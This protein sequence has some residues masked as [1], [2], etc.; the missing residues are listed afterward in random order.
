MDVQAPRSDSELRLIAAD[1]AFLPFT[2]LTCLV[3][4][5]GEIKGT[6]LP[7][8]PLPPCITSNYPVYRSPFISSIAS[9]AA[10]CVPL[11]PAYVLLAQTKESI[12]APSSASSRYSYHS[13]LLDQW[14]FGKQTNRF[15]TE[16]VYRS[17][18]SIFIGRGRE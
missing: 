6:K 10:V 3:E 1:P 16:L 9:S 7:V 8:A 5:A 17:F 14:A 12:E 4:Y 18:P 15:H 2:V 13:K 11:P